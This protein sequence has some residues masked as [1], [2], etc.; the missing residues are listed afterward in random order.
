MKSTSS[1]KS[2]SP[3]VTRVILL[4]A[5]ARMMPVDSRQFAAGAALQPFGIVL[6]QV[7]IGIGLQFRTLRII[8]LGIL[9]PVPREHLVHVA[10]ATLLGQHARTMHQLL[11]GL[12]E[13]EP[14]EAPDSRM[15]VGVHPNRVARASLHA[16]SAVD[17][18]QRVDFVAHREFFNMRIG[19]LARFYID[20]LRRTRRRAKKARSA[21]DRRI[22]TQ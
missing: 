20:T 15:H 17:T 13:I 6:R 22:L 19:R 21:S 14:I 10:V 8:N 16:K 2:V 18:S 11:F 12:D 4:F 5:A 3:I 7:A 9:L 1:P